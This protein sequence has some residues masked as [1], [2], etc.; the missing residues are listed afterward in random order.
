MELLP[1]F[2]IHVMIQGSQYNIMADQCS[3]IN[4]NTT[5]ILEFA[6]RIDEHILSKRDILSEIRIEWRE[7]TER[8]I[9]RFPC[10]F[11]KKINYFLKKF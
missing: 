11:R 8:W 1:F 4:K 7:E 2:G 9:N 5:L 6:S 3:I 10:Q